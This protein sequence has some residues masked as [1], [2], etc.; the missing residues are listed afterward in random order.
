MKDKNDRA[1]DEETIPEG[2]ARRQIALALLGAIGGTA[3]LEGCASGGPASPEE[4]GRS[5]ASLSGGN[6]IQFD[7][8]ASLR[9]TSG[10]A[11]DQCA[12]VENYDAPSS[13]TAP[14][15]GGGGV[16]WWTPDTTTPDDGGV[17]IAKTTGRTGAWDFN[18]YSGKVLFFPL[19]KY[20]VTAIPGY[21]HA[22]EILGNMVLEGERGTM[23]VPDG[24]TIQ[25]QSTGYAA[26]LCEMSSN[27]FR[28]IGFA[29][30]Y[31]AIAIAGMSAYYGG[32]SPAQGI[33]R[34]SFI[35]QCIFD[36]MYGFAIWQDFRPST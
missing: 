16:F 30:F 4:V 13:S 26:M 34:P 7:T 24:T 36:G 8:I 10:T 18:Q 29:N 17:V 15:D 5:L 20:R 11:T 3:F 27:V 14:P 23:L 12:I 22:L 1:A 2:V 6:V 28:N 9:A 31:V 19:G 25:N 21:R 35:D 32:P 33:E